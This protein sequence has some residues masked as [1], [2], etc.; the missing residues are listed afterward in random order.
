M[1]DSQFS[2]ASEDKLE[3]PLVVT[4]NSDRENPLEKMTTDQPCQTGFKPKVREIEVVRVELQK[5]KVVKEVVIY[6]PVA[7]SLL[8]NGIQTDELPQD[9]KTKGIATQ[10]FK[11]SDDREIEV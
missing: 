6:Q 10:A 4:F 8:D 2:H 9:I 7:K 1:I 11:T 3:E 5:D